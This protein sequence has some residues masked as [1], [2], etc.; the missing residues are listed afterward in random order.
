MIRLFLRC[1][2]DT[3]VLENKSPNVLEICT[4]LIKDE[5]I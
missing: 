4:K 3:I 5:M 1:D 2:N